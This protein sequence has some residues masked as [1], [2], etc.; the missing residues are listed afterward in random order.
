MAAIADF[1]IAV[2][3]LNPER[4]GVENYV[5]PMGLMAAVAFSWGVMLVIADQ[6]PLERRWMIVP[7]MLVVALLGL[8]AVHAGWTGLIPAERAVATAV[9]TVTVLLVLTLGWQSTTQDP[10]NVS[11]KD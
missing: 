7:T 4:M 3:V 8:V 2:L 5:Y 11:R 1:I 9:V 6:K 10:K